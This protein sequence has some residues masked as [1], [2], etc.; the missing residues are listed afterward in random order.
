MPLSEGNGQWVSGA[1]GSEA[2]SVQH[3]IDQKKDKKGGRRSRKKK[4]AKHPPGSAFEGGTLE[5]GE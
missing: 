1:G 5:G 3:P 4:V 2:G